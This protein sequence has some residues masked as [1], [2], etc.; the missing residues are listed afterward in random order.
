MKT[1][2]L[3]YGTG[4]GKTANV[5]KKI[6]EAFGE[7]AIEVVSVENATSKDFEKYANLLLGAATWFDGELPSF[8][9]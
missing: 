4:T 2:G 7:A 8:W 6:K 5:A 1:I 9:D 3:F